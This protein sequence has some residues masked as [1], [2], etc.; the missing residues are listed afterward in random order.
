MSINSEQ[1]LEMVY[2]ETL[3][4]TWNLEDFEALLYIAGTLKLESFWKYF[5]TLFPL[6]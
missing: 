1:E 5:E 2:G 3:L 6:E 4:V